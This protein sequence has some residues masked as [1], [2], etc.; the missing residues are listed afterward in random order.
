MLS[1]IDTSSAQTQYTLYVKGPVAGS[2]FVKGDIGALTARK[3]LC[4]ID[5]ERSTNRT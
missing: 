1:K 3:A 5:L 4:V 2:R